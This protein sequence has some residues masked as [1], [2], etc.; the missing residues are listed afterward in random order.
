M[1]FNLKNLSK[2]RDFNTV[3][4]YLRAREGHVQNMKAEIRETTFGRGAECSIIRKFIEKEIL[5]E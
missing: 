2:K 5:G 4:E 1:K 3:I